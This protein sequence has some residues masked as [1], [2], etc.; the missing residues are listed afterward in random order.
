MNTTNPPTCTLTQSQ[1]KVSVLQALGAEIIR[2]P[3]EAAFDSPDSHIEV[4]KT[5]K[6]K[7]GSSAHIL[8]QYSNPSNPDAHE[9]GTGREVAEQLKSIGKKVDVFVATAGTGG[10]I[11]GMAKEL[12]RQFP[13]CIVVGVDP[14]G[15][16][17][18]QPESLN[19]K[20]KNESYKVE[21]IGYDFIPDVLKRSW[22]D[23]WIKSEDRESFVMSRRLIREEGMLV[24]GSSGSAMV[25]VVKTLL[26]DL[27]HLNR[28]DVNVV[29]V[30]ADSVRNYMTKFLR[31]KWMLD[32][33]FGDVVDPQA[34][35]RNLHDEWTIE[36]RGLLMTVLKKNPTVAGRLLRDVFSKL[37]TSVVQGSQSVKKAL[38]TDLVNTDKKPFVVMGKN[39]QMLGVTTEANLLQIVSY[40]LLGKAATLESVTQYFPKFQLLDANKSTVQ[41]AARVLENKAYCGFEKDDRVVVVVSH[42]DVLR[43]LNVG[44]LSKM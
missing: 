8:D 30:F 27:P 38:E 19:E 25:G 24:G 1:E 17:L 2:T 40:G 6:E 37:N 16:I 26:V 31:D 36:N 32:N 39:D 3:T 18:A 7:I 12:K 43:Y 29:V 33:G 23:R 15:S 10:T 22:V 13:G 44:A 28:P 35:A 14:C 21:G 41:D 42:A 4:A 5:M 20:L 9:Q 11:T 34:V